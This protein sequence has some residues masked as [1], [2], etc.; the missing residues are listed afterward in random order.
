M[1]RRPSWLGRVAL[2]EPRSRPAARTCAG[3]DGA[4]AYRGIMIC[5]IIRNLRSDGRGITEARAIGQHPMHD[6]GDFA[7]QRHLG[8][9]HPAPLCELHRPALQCR[10]ALE[11][12]GQYDVGG[13]VKNRAHP[14]ITDFRDATVDV[15][16]ARLVFGWRQAEI[17]SDLLRR[18]EACRVINRRGESE[19]HDGTDAGHRHQQ[20]RPRIA[21]GHGAHLLLEAVEL[22][23]QRDTYRQQALRD[24]LQARMPGNEFANPPFEA[25]WRGWP[26]LEAEA[27]QNAPQTHLDVMKFYLHQLARGEQ[28]AR[29][30]RW[31]RLCNAP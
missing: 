2:S 15:G 22:A 11:W 14:C 24:R 17:G 12:L 5:V 7:R 23:P 26:D 1:E 8:L 31:D 10:A 6:D 29:L 3:L 21:A 18:F 16:F 9:L 4:G 27:T 20:P 13:L 28:R 30:L 25:H 19:R